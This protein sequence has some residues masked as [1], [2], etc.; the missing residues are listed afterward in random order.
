MQSA[1]APAAARNVAR[2]RKSTRLNSSH[3]QISYAVFCFKK[4][5]VYVDLRGCGE[6]IASGVAKSAEHWEGKRILVEP[7]VGT[8]VCWIKR[9]AG[10]NVRPPFAAAVGKVAGQ[11]RSRRARIGSLDALLFF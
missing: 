8:L 4:K 2:D 7:L 10:D 5:H 9:S 1:P 6:N 11:H 3:D